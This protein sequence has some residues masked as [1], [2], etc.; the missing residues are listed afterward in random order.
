M[1]DNPSA[2]D[3]K[4]LL[5]WGSNERIVALFT[6]P[7]GLA[8]LGG[9]LLLSILLKWRV[10]FVVIS[11]ALGVAVLARS[12]LAGGTSAPGRSMFFFAGGAVAIAAFIIYYLFIRED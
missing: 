4:A 8:I 3:W 6:H 10:T 12:T 2:V 5:E 11:A 1:W 7:I 9:V